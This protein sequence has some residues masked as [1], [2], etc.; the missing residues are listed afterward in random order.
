M[1]TTLSAE[2][3]IEKYEADIRAERQRILSSEIAKDPRIREQGLYFLQSIQTTAFN[4]YVAP[5]PQFPALYVH[6]VFMPYELSWG[7]PSPNFLYR[8]SF[9]DGRHTYRIYGN[10]KG[11]FWTNL[12]VFHGF[13]G[14]EVMTTIGVIDFDNLPKKPNGDYE[15]F[16]G[17]SP[18]ADPKSQTWVK[19][20][21]VD[22]ITVQVRDATYNWA[23]MHTAD[24][25]VEI[26]DRDPDASLHIDEADFV[27]RLEKATRWMRRNVAFAGGFLRSALTG[28][29]TRPMGPDETVDPALVRDLSRRNQFREVTSAA[30]PPG[31]SSA[32][33]G[34][35]LSS[36]AQ[37]V[38]DLKP[39]EAL[40]IEIPPIKARF[41]DL[42][43]GDLW[44]QTTDYS[45]HRSSVNGHEARVD[46]DGLIR[47][48]LTAADPGVTNWLD[49]AHVP[50]GM[51]LLR[52]YHLEGRGA[53]KTKLVK[54]SEVRR[55]LPP[56]TALTSPEERRAEMAIRK[57][58]SLRRYGY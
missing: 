39:D 45:H 1:A 11:N 40:I 18:P 47:A 8:W 58:A 57:E 16:L 37:M 21:P 42:Q 38:Y 22:S 46:G 43:L 56:D 6:Q 13:W 54:R 27:R 28:D 17:P 55:H 15:I 50:M 35:P 44:G 24:M 31:Q 23:D 26:L 29:P 41:W 12:Q 5:R 52:R 25:R 7:L 51:A 33:A 36:F 53:P 32:F 3:A 9:L 14:D 34:S 20:D 10:A 2:K 4:M 49:Y 48:V 30:P 19:L